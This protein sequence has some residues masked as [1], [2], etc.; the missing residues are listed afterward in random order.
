MKRKRAKRHHYVPQTLLRGFVNEDG[1]I[2]VSEKGM[3]GRF[4]SPEERN[5]AGAFWRRNY[6]MTLE[7]WRPSDRLETG[8][9]SSVDNFLGD[10]FHQVECAFS[11]GRIPKIEGGLKG[12]LCDVVAVLMKRS[13]ETQ[14]L[15]DPLEIGK[16]IVADVFAGCEGSDVGSEPLP[17]DA[18]NPVHVAWIGRHVLATACA[19]PAK[20]VAAALNEFGIRWV[21]P[22]RK[23]SFVVW[24]A[25]MM[26]AGNGQAST[27]LDNPKVEVLFPISSRRMLVFTKNSGF[28]DVNVAP[29]NW[30]RRWNL[31]NCRA[32]RVVGG[33][34]RKLVDSL[35]S[36]RAL[37]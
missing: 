10:L 14:D 33:C 31:N 9:W 37:E 20:S 30:V 27:A 7:D 15:Y 13:P 4:S 5:T 24:S 28:P 26:R 23:S 3:D 36:C 8:F 12:E 17:F 19:S 22:E 35:T 6:N 34:S 16:E 11:A 18:S 25:I 2:W 21:I 32:S 29:G 1:K